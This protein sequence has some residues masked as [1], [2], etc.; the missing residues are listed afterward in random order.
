MKKQT[1]D[2]RQVRRRHKEDQFLGRRQ[3]DQATNF[4][5]L[6]HMTSPHIKL[7]R[8]VSQHVLVPHRLNAQDHNRLLSFYLPSLSSPHHHHN[9]HSSQ[10]EAPRQLLTSQSNYRKN[11]AGSLERTPAP[12]ISHGIRGGN[13]RTSARTTTH[14]IINGISYTTCQHQPALD[15]NYKRS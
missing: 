7:K 15:H 2:L 5:S 4:I 13:L 1:L 3:P 10:W 8:M 9:P 12:S 6:Q 14:D 11:P